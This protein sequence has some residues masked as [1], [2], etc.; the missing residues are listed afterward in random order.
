MGDSVPPPPPLPR[1]AAILHLVIPSA[2]VSAPLHWSLQR[3]RPA[4]SVAERGS[5]VSLLGAVKVSGS[6]RRVEV[7][8]Q[9][10][11]ASPH[12]GWRLALQDGLAGNHAGKSYFRP[13]GCNCQA[14]QSEREDREWKYLSFIEV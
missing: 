13:H 12:N 10:S 5:A 6:N 3:T 9:R 14:A 1:L 8:D 11:E 2:R 4:L 7:F